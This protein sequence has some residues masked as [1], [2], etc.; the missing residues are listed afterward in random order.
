MASYVALSL[1]TGRS[2]ARTM[3]FYSRFASPCSSR[4]QQGIFGNGFRRNAQACM[5]RRA[6]RSFFSLLIPLYFSYAYAVYAWT[7]EALLFLLPGLQG[8]TP[9]PGACGLA[10]R[11][12]GNSLAAHR[13][14]HA[15]TL[16]SKACIPPLLRCCVHLRHSGQSVPHGGHSTQRKT[17]GRYTK[18]VS[19]RVSAQ[20]VALCHLATQYFLPALIPAHIN[21]LHTDLFLLSLTILL[22]CAVG[23]LAVRLPRLRMM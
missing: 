9:P 12:G 3:H 8:K 13:V 2:P 18:R 5:Q 14:P 4:A 20:P 22:G 1:L 6:L 16:P 17:N 19:I 7:A 15:A 21:A 23:C 11:R 10:G